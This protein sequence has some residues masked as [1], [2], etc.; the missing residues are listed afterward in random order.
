MQ[1]FA[2]KFLPG[3]E[4]SAST[5]GNYLVLSKGI[6]FSLME[7]KRAEP[8]IASSAIGRIYQQVFKLSSLP[9]W[10]LFSSN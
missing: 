8:N 7:Q 9:W 1:I 5:C 10:Q 3:L 2:L 4:Q 6:S